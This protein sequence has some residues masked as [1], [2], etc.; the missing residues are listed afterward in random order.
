[1][2]STE[3]CL[4]EPYIISNYPFYVHLI[5][6]E[7]ILPKKRRLVPSPASRPSK[8][9]RPR[10]PSCSRG[11]GRRPTGRHR[12]ER[13]RERWSG[14]PASVSRRKLFES[15]NV[16]FQNC[17]FTFRLTREKKESQNSIVFT[18][19]EC[20][21]WCFL[22]QKMLNEMKLSDLPD[23]LWSAFPLDRRPLLRWGWCSAFGRSREPRSTSCTSSLA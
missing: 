23:L 19:M 16:Q 5:I 21:S 6:A 8:L 2:L 10:P 7:Q 3:F 12:A 9:E 4:L 11:S 15:G 14:C 17:F 18:P 20:K 1:M 22:H 13:D